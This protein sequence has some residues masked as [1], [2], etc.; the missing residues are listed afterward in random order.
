MMG[1]DL[2]AG[3]PPDTAVTF[4][5]TGVEVTG[6]RTAKI[7]GDLTLNGITSPV[8]LD[9]TMR[10]VGQDPVVGKPSVGFQATGTLLRSDFG[11]G[12]FAPAVSDEVQLEVNVEAHKG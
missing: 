5:S 3:D 10:G 9:V 2:F 8:T 4:A 11:L 1:D 12:A 7:T 6:D